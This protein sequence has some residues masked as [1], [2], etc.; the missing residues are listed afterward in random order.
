MQVV[1]FVIVIADAREES[2]P[3]VRAV[4]VRIVVCGRAVLR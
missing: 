4:E 1:V 3:R 2:R